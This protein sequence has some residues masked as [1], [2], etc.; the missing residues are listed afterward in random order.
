[1]VAELR[2][3]FLAVPLAA[4]ARS[5]LAQHLS[6]WDPPG[7]LVPPENWHLTVRFLGQIDETRG[8]ILVGLVDQADLGRPFD[9]VLTD[10]GA[11]P[12]GSRANVLWLGVEDEDGG[13][14]RLNAT[15]EE[16]ARS[17]GLVP[18]ERPFSAHLTLSRL[19]P[20]VNVTALIDSYE[21]QPFRWTV[22]E[23]ILYESRSGPVYPEVER[24][25]LDRPQPSSRR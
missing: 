12:G 4:S 17:A 6:R 7:K 16:A 14:A 15:V 3:L 1:V 21:S 20:P 8:E 23:L 11:F 10:M 18:E 24:F 25:S 22:N 2:R 9:L 5:M 13:L 19:R